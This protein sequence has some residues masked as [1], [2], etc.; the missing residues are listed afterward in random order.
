MVMH[1]LFTRARARAHTHTRTH[2]HTQAFYRVYCLHIVV[3]HLLFA[4]AFAGPDVTVISSAVLSHAAMHALERLSNWWMTRPQVLGSS[5]H[6]RQAC[7]LL[8]H[9]IAPPAS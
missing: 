5:E 2:A 6:V 3:L 8:K 1:V 4:Y 7:F 9:S